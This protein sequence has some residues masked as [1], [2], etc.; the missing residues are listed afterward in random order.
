[1]TKRHAPPLP[2]LAEILILSGRATIR[3]NYWFADTWQ[4]RH[5]GS[6]NNASFFPPIFI[7]KSL[8]HSGGKSFCSCEPTWLSRRQ[9]QT[10]NA[11][12]T[13]DCSW[14]IKPAENWCESKRA[15]FFYSRCAIFFNV[16]Y[17][18][19]CLRKK[20]MPL[21]LEERFYSKSISVDL[22]LVYRLFS[23]CQWLVTN[24]QTN[25]NRYRLFIDVLSSMVL[26]KPIITPCFLIKIFALSVRKTY[27]SGAW[28]IIF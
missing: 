28:A 21:P 14:Q 13:R 8:V 3:V 16:Y 19:K 23:A 2:I 12:S 18:W 11:N 20:K 10:S 27:V 9:M 26:G 17:A 15:G 25:Q 4:C 7:E 22:W 1:M 6:Q 5:V 24:K